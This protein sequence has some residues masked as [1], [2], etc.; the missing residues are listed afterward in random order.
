MI[1]R[2]AIERSDVGSLQHEAISIEISF[3]AITVGKDPHPQRKPLPH[4]SK[5]ST[6]SSYPTIGQLSSRVRIDLKA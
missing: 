1:L 2:M 5:E 6:Q 3:A 4:L